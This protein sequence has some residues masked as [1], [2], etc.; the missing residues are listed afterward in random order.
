M[1]LAKLVLGASLVTSMFMGSTAL[2]SASE[3]N[4]VNPNARNQPVV[5]NEESNVMPIMVNE[6]MP[7]VFANHIALSAAISTNGNYWL[8]PGGYKYNRINVQNNGTQ[9]LTVYITEDNYTSKMG[10]IAPKSSR[11]WTAGPLHAIPTNCKKFFLDYSTPNGVVS[12]TATVRVST[13]PL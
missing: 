5:I 13:T 4:Y 3:D 9:T 2:A 7:E 8:Q 6:D 12:G 1:K 10:T 11:T